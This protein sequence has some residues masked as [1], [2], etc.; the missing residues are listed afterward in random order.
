MRKQKCYKKLRRERN[1][2]SSGLLI[3]MIKLIIVFFLYNAGADDK[4][5][6]EVFREVLGQCGF[7]ETKGSNWGPIV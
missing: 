5:I 1:G 4:L 6:R 3:K 2:S 7:R